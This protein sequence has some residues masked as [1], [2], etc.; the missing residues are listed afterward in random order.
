MGLFGFLKKVNEKRKEINEEIKRDDAF[1]DFIFSLEDNSYEIDSENPYAG[2][3]K[4]ISK[5]EMSEPQEEFI[6]SLKRKPDKDVDYWSFIKRRG[7]TSLPESYIVFDLETTGL[8]PH[9]EGITEIAA[10]KFDHDEPIE[11]FHTYVN[12]GKRISVKIEDLTGITNDIVADAP[13]IDYVLPNFLKFIDK[14]TLVAHNASFDM[15]FILDKMY[16][17]GYKKLGNKSIDTL[18]LSRKYVK[19]EDTDKRLSSY[20]LEDLKYELCFPMKIVKM[21]SHNAL[22]DVKVTYFL[23]KKC[24]ELKEDDD[25]FKENLKKI[26]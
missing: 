9:A 18:A 2:T 14:Y 11:Y 6:N 17:A 7:T 5:F 4:P 12:P 24:R 15:S 25:R 16:N 8:E 19:D 21:N 26:K 3:F 23:Y 1:V 13:T 20:K 10:I 22:Y